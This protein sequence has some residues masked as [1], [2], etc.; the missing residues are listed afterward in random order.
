M[1][2]VPTYSV[3]FKRPDAHAAPLGFLRVV[4]EGENGV[5]IAQYGVRLLGVQGNGAQQE[6]DQG[7]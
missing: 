7:E 2:P 1:L 4:V 6:D 3:L 5:V